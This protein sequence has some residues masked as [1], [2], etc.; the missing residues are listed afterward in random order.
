MINSTGV[1]C[2]SFAGRSGGAT[3]VVRDATRVSTAASRFIG[4]GDREREIEKVITITTPIDKAVI[5]PH[6]VCS[7]ASG[8]SRPTSEAVNWTHANEQRRVLARNGGRGTFK[9][10]PNRTRRLRGTCGESKS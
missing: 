4:F 10:A 8:P 7:T 6:I 1:A 9:S 5:Y 2:A 3:K